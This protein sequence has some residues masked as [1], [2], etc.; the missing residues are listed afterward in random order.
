VARTGGQAV[1]ELS[2]DGPGITDEEAERVFERFYRADPSRSR[3][4]GGAGL[5]LSIVAA[6]VA[7]H[8]GVVTAAPRRP[9]GAVFSVR[10][11]VVP[12][13]VGKTGGEV[14]SP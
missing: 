11:P 3:L 5:G 6:I 2:D 7:G 14:V 10:L 9:R 8:G 13:T 12:S 4:S 1:L